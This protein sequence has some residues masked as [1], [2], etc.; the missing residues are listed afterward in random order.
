[1]A[2]IYQRASFS[3]YDANIEIPGVVSGTN[4]VTVKFKN[5][6]TN[7]IDLGCGALQVKVS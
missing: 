3:I 4:Q 7:P 5:I 1:M 6:G 2:N